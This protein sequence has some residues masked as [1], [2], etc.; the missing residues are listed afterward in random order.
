MPYKLISFAGV[1][2]PTWAYNWDVG[3]AD[4]LDLDI[5]LPYGSFLDQ[6]GSQRAVPVLPRILPYSVIGVQASTAA[7]VTAYDALKRVLRKTGELIREDEQGT[8]QM[9]EARL[10][11]IS[12]IHTAKYEG[13][14]WQAFDLTFSLKSLWQGTAH[15]AGSYYFDEGNY[16]DTGIYFD[17]TVGQTVVDDISAQSSIS[18]SLPNGGTADQRN[19]KITF[20]LIDILHDPPENDG[21]IT[22]ITFACNDAAWVFSGTLDYVSSTPSARAVLEVDCG[23]RTVFAEGVE[24]FEYFDMAAGHRGRAWLIL[25]PGDSSATVTWERV[26]GNCPLVITATYYDLYD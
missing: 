25:P 4:T 9:C 3:T 12:S 2:L 18:F 24:A 11:K 8:Q 5:Q 20:E 26:S 7:V 16:F 19:I 15:P 23:K 17:E 1:D 22:N 14:T 6:F 10:T 21:S 13:V